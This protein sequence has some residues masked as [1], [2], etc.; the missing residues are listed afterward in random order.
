[1]IGG[2]CTWEFDPH[3]LRGKSPTRD[4]LDRR[5]HEG[6]DLAGASFHF[7]SSELDAGPVICDGERTRVL[8]ND[9]PEMLR[10]RNYESSKIPVMIEG[11][12]YLRRNFDQLIGNRPDHQ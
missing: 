3:Q 8:P 10:A 1:L 11:L 12:R 2:Q 5:A 4:A 9:T 6:Y 7:I